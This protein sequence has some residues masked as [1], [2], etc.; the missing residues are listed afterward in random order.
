VLRQWAAEASAS[1]FYAPDYDPAGAVGP[2]NV[3]ACQDSPD[4]WASADPNGLETLELRFKT[5]VF[6]VGVNV[7]QNHQPGFISQVELIDERGVARVVYSGEPA[8]LS[9]CPFVLQLTFDQTLTRIVAVRLTIDQ[10]SG[11]NW[12]EVDTVELVGLR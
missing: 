1:S 7:H 11:A 6:A 4:A 2:P 8:L 5:P 3:P 10:R 12:S 9:N